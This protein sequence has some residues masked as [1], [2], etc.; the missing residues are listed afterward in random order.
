[1][2]K[3]L[4]SDL[5]FD[6]INLS[7]ALSRSK[8]I[9]Y[10]INSENFRNWLRKELEGYEY[11]DKLL[12]GYRV[13]NCQ[14]YI[15]HSLPNGKKYSKPIVVAEDANKEFYEEVNY[16]RALD[17]VSIIEQH[18]ATIKDIGYIFLKT[19]EAYAIAQGDEYQNWVVGGYREIGKGQLQNIIELTK[20]KLLDT[21]L[22]LD[23]LFP[24][25][26]DGFKNTKDNMEK[27]QNIITA[28]IYGNNNPMNIVA[29][30][31]VKLN[32][33]STVLYTKDCDELEK[34]GVDIKQIDELKQIIQA[35]NSDKTT[36][37]Q[38]MV[39]WLGSVSAS[40]AAKGLYD[41]IPAISEFISKII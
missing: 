6:K 21:L 23:V 13:I 1:M 3:D 25:L 37:K 34:L 30:L 14:M 31:D 24:T 29:G 36:L 18:A 38:K 39:K 7:Q 15:T 17:P 32:D 16:F 2:I 4:I 40:I 27:V 12:P 11:S 41:N 10:K 19:E 20:Q 8:I 33:I 9:A 35:H 28:N 26:T 22:E 5:A